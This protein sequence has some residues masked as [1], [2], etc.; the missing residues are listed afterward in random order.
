[1]I[2]DTRLGIWWGLNEDQYLDSGVC[3]SVLAFGFSL[4]FTGKVF[5]TV[6]LGWMS[7]AVAIEAAD[8]DANEVLIA[9]CTRERRRR[10][11]GLGFTVFFFSC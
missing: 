7:S 6:V 5:A 3:E 2:E 8:D 9:I 1:M 10:K 11:C 4:G